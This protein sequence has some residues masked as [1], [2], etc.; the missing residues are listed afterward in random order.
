MNKRNSLLAA[1]SSAVLTVALTACGGGGGGGGDDNPPAGNVSPSDPNAVMDALAASVGSSAADLMPGSPPAASNDSEAP[2]VEAGADDVN[3]T[4]G[5]DVELVVSTQ[6]SQAIASLFAKVP[7]ADKY[8]EFSEPDPDGKSMAKAG[9]V[10]AKATVATFDLGTIYILT[11]TL[12]DNIDEGEF[13]L[14]V[15]AQDADGLVSQPAPICVSVV[16]EIVV[17]ADD[18][19]AQIE[20][21]AAALDGQWL[22]DCFD[23]EGDETYES[24]KFAFGFDQAVGYTSAYQLWDVEDCVGEPEVLDGIFGTFDIQDDGTQADYATSFDSQLGIWQRAFDFVPSS[25]FSLVDPET[26]ETY[27]LGTCYNVLSVSGDT[28]FLGVPIAFSV[29]RELSGE[30]SI[31]DSAETR[32]SRVQTGLALSRVDG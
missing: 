17:P 27:P 3:A 4:P 28:L 6:A 15:S 7:G 13:C 23:I 29:P 25:E 24:L 11:L 16:D 19:P 1:L 5:G 12:P 26:L 10:E 8:F 9:G 20:T 30:E 18:Q 2:K 21:L 22:S 31:C 32:P 14:N